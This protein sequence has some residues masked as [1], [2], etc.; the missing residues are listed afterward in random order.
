[1]IESGFK[2]F[3]DGRSELFEQTGVLADYVYIKQLEPRTLQVLRGYGIRSVL[4]GRGEPL[5][6]VLAASPEWRRVYSDGVSELYVKQD[7][8]DAPTQVSAESLPASTR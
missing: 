8:G 2:T 1:M 3:V 6:T 4:M 7:A 5:L